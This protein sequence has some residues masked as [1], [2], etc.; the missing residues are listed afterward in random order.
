MTASALYRGTLEHVR[1]RAPAHRFRH[2]LY[3]LYLDLDELPALARPPIFG[4]EAPGLLAFRRRDYFG[5]AAAPLKDAV[6]DAV[7][8]ELG[9]RPRGP[10]R[11]LTQVRSFG[12]AFNPVSFYYC[13]AADGG[14][15]E[16][17]LS[18]ITNTPWGERHAYVV[19]GNGAGAGAVFQ[20][21]FHVSPFLPP[22]ER[23]AWRFSVPGSRLAVA[24]RSDAGGERSFRASLVLR[25][26]ELTARSLAWSALARPFM[27]AR[28]LTWI[29]RHALELRLKG[30]PV[31]PHPKH[32]FEEEHRSR[33]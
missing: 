2:D 22:A 9:H 1:S 18:E 16:A 17:V 4:V 11:L 29:Y 19:A 5:P 28:I 10:V 27:S 30:A 15:L 21:A 23:Y 33:A 12:R 31:Y 8:R 13:F 26:S 6:L 25:R 14:R 7:E 32:V 20:K 24:M 3:M